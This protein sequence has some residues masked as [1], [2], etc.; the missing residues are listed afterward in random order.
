MNTDWFTSAKESL[1]S[2]SE[3][4][5]YPGAKASSF[6]IKAAPDLAVAVGLTGIVPTTVFAL[7]LAALFWFV[8]G[9]FVLK[10]V[11]LCSDI[12]RMIESALKVVV[13]RCRMFAHHFR[14]GLMV[15][16]GLVVPDGQIIVQEDGQG[17]DLDEIDIEILKTTGSFGPGFAVSAPELAQQFNMRP[18]QLQRRLDRLR[19]FK[20]LDYV[21][22]TTDGYDN[23]RLAG[24]G[25]A[26]VNM[27]SSDG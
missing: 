10:F 1:A 14:N 21:L 26:F 9:M 27:W 13:F 23:Y 7:L 3:A 2:L 11:R 18:S 5:L 25:A 19:R 12:L 15:R 6:L 22:G 8:V 16:L 17:V 20:F 4:L 24:A